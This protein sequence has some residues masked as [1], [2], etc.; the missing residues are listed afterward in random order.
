MAKGLTSA[1]ID[2]LPLTEADKARLAA[3]YGVGYTPA[4]TVASAD[5]LAAFGRPAAVVDEKAAAAQK[6]ADMGYAPGEVKIIQPKPVYVP[7]APASS[8]IGKIA[9]A[10]PVAAEANAGPGLEVDSAGIGYAMVPKFVNKWNGAD[11]S[12][13]TA[14]DFGMYGVDEGDKITAKAP[15]GQ[16]EFDAEKLSAK[17]PVQEPEVPKKYAAKGK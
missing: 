10:Q 12:E 8:A 11:Q 16:Y 9:Y 17:P 1:E 6:A 4:K 3:H 7:V 14:D 15:K 13:Y 5:A 2:K